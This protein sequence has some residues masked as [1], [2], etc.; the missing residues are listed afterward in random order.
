M[1]LITCHLLTVPN[2]AAFLSALSA[3][4]AALR[5]IYVGEVHHWIHE[6]TLSTAALTGTGPNMHAW[7]HLLIHQTA[8]PTSLTLPLDSLAEQVS[9]RWSITAPAS[10][11][12]LADFAGA[13]AARSTKLAPPL[14]L[15]W[16]AQDPSGLKAAQPP[17][18]LQ[19]S[20]GL[21]SVRL[22]GERDG[23]AIGLKDFVAE[24]GAKHTGPVSMFNLLAY[25]SG[26]RS[27]YFEYIAA[28]Q[29]S[30]GVKYG[31]EGLLA[32]GVMEWSSRK[33][34]GAQVADPDKNGSAVWEDMALVWYPSL[35]HFAK[36][37]DDQEYAAVDRAYKQGAL[38]DN[39]LVVCTE[40]E[41]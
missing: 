25:H 27:R 4:P 19:A 29:S 28:F 12:M 14:P 23:P 38:K 39:P 40:V 15:G 22:G 35:W 37:F 31:G 20:L 33:E 6:P 32:A 8:S 18:D 17:A 36:M 11:D 24:F 30:V 9:A 26:Q 5:P 7:T 10:D 34:E 21:A 3:L 2:S 41:L 1:A 13:K 16:S